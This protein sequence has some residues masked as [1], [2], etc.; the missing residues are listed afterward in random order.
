M[1]LRE[2]VEKLGFKVLVGEEQL[3]QEA[4]GGYVAD[5]LSCVMAGAKA[6]SVWVTLQTHANIV[7]VAALNE[8]A[9]IVIAEN[10]V[11][12]Q[13]TLDKAE[14]QDVVILS[15]PEPVYETVGRLIAL[16]V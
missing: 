4:R 8:L 10:A 6:Q 1:T 13:A 5:L 2:I 7:A 9:C 11:V 12:P 14:E 15:S 3:D 16:G